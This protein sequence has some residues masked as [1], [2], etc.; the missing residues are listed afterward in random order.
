MNELQFLTWVRGPG[1]DIAVGIFVLGVLWRLIEIYTLGRRKDLAPPRHA[2][3]ASGLHTV[4]RRSLAPPGMLKRSP[5]SYIGGYFFHIGLAII[6]FLGAPHILLISNLTGLSWPALPAQFI[7]LVAVVTMAAMVVMLFDR[8][9]KPAKRFLST[10]EDWFTWAVTFLPVLTGW[11]AVQ[12]LLLPY[13]TM[14]ALHILSAEILL[15]VLPFTKL[16][17]AFTLFGSRWYNGSAN[18]R[19][20]VPV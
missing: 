4:F 20:G 12:H 3:G 18:A 8:I 9:N 14:L 19:K 16:F 10:F 2:A 11:L 15:I 6:V 7:D 17:H 5:V 1:L 13:T